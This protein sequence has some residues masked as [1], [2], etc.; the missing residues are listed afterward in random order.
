[1]SKRT[2]LNY[3]SLGLNPAELAD[4]YDQQ[5][6]PLEYRDDNKR[7]KYKHTRAH[8][9]VRYE[10]YGNRKKL[11]VHE[12][13]RHAIEI[14][15]MA[16]ARAKNPEIS[17]SFGIDSVV[18]I[19]IV[20]QAL[21]EMGRELSS[22]KVVW[23]D[24]LNEF[25]TVR[26]YAKQMTE[27]LNLDLVVTKPLKPL[28]K[29]IEDNGGITSDY[30]T[31]R[32]GSRSQGMPLSERCC[33]TLKHEPMHRAI[34]ENGYDLII[35][36]LRADESRQR[37]QASLRDGEYFYS[38]GTWKAYILRPILWISDEEIWEYVFSEGIPYNELYDQNV[39]REF[40]DNHAFLVSELGDKL[41]RLGMD[42]DKFMDQQI[43]IVNKP[44]SL[45]LAKHGYKMFTPRTG[46]MQCPIPI[47]YGYL[48]FMRL[49]YPKIYSSMIYNLGYGK[50]LLDMVP[51][52]VKDEVYA[53]TGIKIDEENAHEH[54]KEVIESKPCVFDKF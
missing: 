38:S 25:P 43:A 18:T 3:Q 4:L 44:Q 21:K 15:K 11:T 34:K 52:E 6:H 14:T 54:L 48:Q 42:V 33:G 1:M 28:K 50:A 23:N 17:C 46:C 2:A 27:E 22:I 51:Q 31:A 8:K 29:I 9:A 24:T 19:Y 13:V 53:M 40:P 39:I 10:N 45:L 30:F 26:K 36:G 20:K 12:K 35:N 5:V 32:K 7:K 37:L 47:K 41:E 16:L 49:V